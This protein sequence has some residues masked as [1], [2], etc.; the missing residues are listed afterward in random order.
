MVFR[1][2]G[3]EAVV[4]QVVPVVA[5]R[6]PAPRKEQLLEQRRSLFALGAADRADRGFIGVPRNRDAGLFPQRQQPLVDLPGVGRV[7]A[8]A[9]IG[10]HVEILLAVAHHFILIV[11]V[12][13][14]GMGAEP[15]ETGGEYG[16]AGIDRLDRGVGHLGEIDVVGGAEVA[17]R[18]KIGFVPDLPDADAS[19]KMTGGGLHIAFPCVE[20]GFG[21]VPLLPLWGVAGGFRRGPAGAEAEHALRFDAVPGEQVD[22]RIEEPVVRRGRGRL[23]V[24]PVDAGTHVCRA[25]AGG[26]LRF[27]FAFPLRPASGMGADAEL[28]V[29]RLRL[30]GGQSGQDRKSRLAVA[31]SLPERT[32]QSSCQWPFRAGCPGTE[33]VTLWPGA[34]F[35]S[36]RKGRAFP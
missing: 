2:G 7:V 11:R 22:D 27:K 6:A 31:A 34:S 30:I 5:D 29:V 18:I 20:V 8:V 21:A 15:R 24:A 10:V 3:G 12:A 4:A 16:Q 17:E 36:A 19:L 23:D 33:T 35:R 14:P 1:V 26:R 28:E 9:V 32:V 13:P 25:D